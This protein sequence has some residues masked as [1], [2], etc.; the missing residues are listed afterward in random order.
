M[1]IMDAV[2]KQTE[3]SQRVL[4]GTATDADRV[5]LA[6]LTEKLVGATQATGNANAV[7]AE[8]DL[9]NAAEFE[10]FLADE[11]AALAKAPDLDRLALLRENVE[12]VRKQVAKGRTVFAVR[13]PVIEKVDPIEAILL[14]L[15][16]MEKRYEFNQRY[17]TGVGP[18]VVRQPTPVAPVAAP[19][20]APVVEAPSAPVIEQAKDAL[21]KDAIDS[22]LTLSSVDA[23]L[24]AISALTAKA[25]DEADDS[26]ELR[27]LLDGTYDLAHLVT[28]AATI[29]QKAADLVEAAQALEKAKATRTA[30]PKAPPFPPAEEAPNGAPET[31]L[32]ED[33]ESEDDMKGRGAGGKKKPAAAKATEPATTEPATT[34]P[35]ATDGVTK[36]AWSED[37]SPTEANVGDRFRAFKRACSSRPT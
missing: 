8:M 33:E 22:V 7:K 21:S 1:T 19:V 18:K 26:D 3:L 36:F 10:K 25:A 17:S 5:E 13:V 11:Q 37:L 35:E 20:A 24:S 27:K 31:D 32:D 4:A 30:K 29:A 28:C 9:M 34:E 2:R 12:G 16:E 14:R 23:L 6:S 15:D